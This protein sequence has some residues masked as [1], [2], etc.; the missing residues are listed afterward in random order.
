M[1]SVG[2]WDTATLLRQC[3]YSSRDIA[4]NP[5]P[6]DVFVRGHSATAGHRINR[7]RNDPAVGE[8][9]DSCALGDAAP[10]QFADVLTGLRR[11]L[12][13]QTQPM[14]DQLLDRGSRPDLLRTKSI[15]FHVP[16]VAEHKLIVAVENHESQRE[17]VDGNLEQPAWGNRFSVEGGLRGIHHG[18]VSATGLQRWQ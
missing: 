1:L 10:D 11:S 2:S 4:G 7:E 18:A 8:F 3:R 6:R 5:P 15:D 16:L 17:I 14:L 9:L 12:K 13:S